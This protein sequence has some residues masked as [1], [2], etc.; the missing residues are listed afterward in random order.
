MVHSHSGPR[1]SDGAQIPGGKVRPSVCMTLFSYSCC[2]G[3]GNARVQEGTTKC[4]VR[5]KEVKSQTSEPLA[6]FLSGETY[7]NL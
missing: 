5:A 1:K 7:T 6:C 3:E 2:W 4:R